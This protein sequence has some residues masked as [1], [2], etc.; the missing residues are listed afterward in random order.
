MKT[1]LEW[2][3]ELDEMNHMVSQ[4]GNPS[5]LKMIITSLKYA[6]NDEQSPL[7]TNEVKKGEFLKAIMNSQGMERTVAAD[8]FKKVYGQEV[9][10]PKMGTP[11]GIMA[12]QAGKGMVQGSQDRENI[13]DTIARAQQAANNFRNKPR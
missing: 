11:G 8:L 10:A 1:F 7:R 6:A 5:N 13:Q 12:N 3:E 9:P 4:T 2:I